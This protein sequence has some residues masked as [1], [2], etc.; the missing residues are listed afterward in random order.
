MK[1][2]IKLFLLMSLLLGVLYPLSITFIA[3]LTMPRKSQGQLLH[4]NGKVIG[5]KLIGQKFTHPQYFWPRPSAVDYE[6]LPSGA[7]NFGPTSQKLHDKIQERRLKIAQAHPLQDPLAIPS[8]LLCTSAS[9]IDPHISL[10]TAYFQLARVAQARSMT[11]EDMINKIKELIHQNLDIPV[12]R[13]FGEP[14]VNVLMLNLALD[15]LQNNLPSS[16]SMKIKN[17]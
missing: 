13:L 4:S 16:P 12:G 15:R 9:G 17:E 11:R 3:N 10:S 7:S 5:S 6:T 1:A 8:E 14:H 2:S